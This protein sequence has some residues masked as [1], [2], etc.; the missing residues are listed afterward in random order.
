MS[1]YISY[2]EVLK[3]SNREG[4]VVIQFEVSEDSRVQKLKVLS[5]NEQLNASLLKQLTGRKLDVLPTDTNQMQ[6]VRLRFQID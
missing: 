2:P 6:T 1:N 4:V 3:E 5:E